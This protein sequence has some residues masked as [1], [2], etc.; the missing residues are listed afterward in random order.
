MDRAF[1]LLGEVQAL[2]L[3]AASPRPREA[4]AICRTLLRGCRLA[5]DARSATVQA[6]IEALGASG[7]RVRKPR[8][9]SPDE[10]R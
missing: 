9:R 4:V 2:E 6:L 3:L 7:G 1:A 5:G 10:G 8:A